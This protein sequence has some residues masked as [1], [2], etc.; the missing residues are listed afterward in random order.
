C[1]DTDDISITV[2]N[3]VPTSVGEQIEICEGEE[4]NLFA[5]GGIAYYWTPSINLSNNEIPNP[6][7]RPAVTTSYKVV[8]TENECYKDTL[9]Q[10]VIVHPLPTINLGTDINAIA[11]AQMELNAQTT[12][13]TSIIWT[14]PINLNCSD[15]FN[16]I[17]TF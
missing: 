14:P 17:A 5:S 3:R 13:A 4:A 7:A 6:T 11:G 9:E 2:A 10:M 16:P 15:C 12:N 8:I 1:S